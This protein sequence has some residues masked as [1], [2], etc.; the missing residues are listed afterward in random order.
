MRLFVSAKKAAGPVQMPYLLFQCMTQRVCRQNIFI[1]I[2]VFDFLPHDPICHGVDIKSGN[3]T[4]ESVGFYERSATTHERVGDLE[5]FKV[6]G[7]IKRGRQRGVKEFGQ[8]QPT[9]QGPWPPGKPFVYS[10][11]WSVVLLNLLFP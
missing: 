3:V 9:E 11:N 5:P 1:E 7:L 6:V 10:D 4:S 8:Q 2:E